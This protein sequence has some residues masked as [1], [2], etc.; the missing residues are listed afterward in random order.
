MLLKKN[1][2]SPPKGHSY[3]E[4]ALTLDCPIGTVNSRLHRGHAL[5]LKK[6][7]AAV[8]LDLAAPDAQGMRRFA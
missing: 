2:D 4:A 7:R 8:R 3:A 6:L 5:L 1:P